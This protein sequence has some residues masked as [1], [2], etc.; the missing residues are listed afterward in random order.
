MAVSL[1]SRLNGSRLRTS[2]T[3]GL[4]IL[5]VLLSM[6]AFAQQSAET[7]HGTVSRIS[8]HGQSLEGNLEGDSPEREVSVYLPPG[9]EAHKSHRYPVVYLLHGFTDTDLR[10]F[11][12]EPLFNGTAAADRA[13]SNGTPEMIVVMP[14]AKTRYFGSMYTSSPATGDWETFVT[15]DLVA[16][17]DSHY[18]TIPNRMSRGLAGHSMGGYGTIRLGMK[19]PEVFSSIYSLSACCLAPQNLQDPARAKSPD[20]KT[21]EQLAAADFMTK[22]QFASAAAWSP[23]PRNP[24]RFIDLPWKDGQ[25]QPMV[26][27]KWAANAPLVMFDQYVANL[28]RLHAIALDVGTHDSLMPGSQ[29]MDEALTAYGIV[30]SYESYDGDHL[31]RVESRFETKVL[32]FFAVNLEFNSAARKGSKHD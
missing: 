22:A 3:S 15:H 8:V 30:H 19:H 2:A 12:S 25:F 24:P 17:I 18:R 1:A 9:Y 27:D 13:F 31:N 32:P 23:D 5:S 7:K 4:A 14:N 10:W 21:D 26:A 28:K 11:G 16:Y 6:A 29:A 20:I